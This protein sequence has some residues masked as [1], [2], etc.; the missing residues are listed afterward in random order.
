MPDAQRRD[1]LPLM[2][3]TTA[4][5]WPSA[6]RRTRRTRRAKIKRENNK[7]RERKKD[8]EREGERERYATLTGHQ[9]VVPW[10]S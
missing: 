10:R 8:K 7:A 4:N 3:G 1:K 9:A 6:R 2:N 5:S